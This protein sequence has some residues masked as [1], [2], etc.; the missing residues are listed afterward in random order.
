MGPQASER[1]LDRLREGLTADLLI[2]DL[3]IPREDGALTFQQI[4]QRWPRLAVLVCTG[5][6]QTD[7]GT[8]TLQGE[9]VQLLRKPFRMNELWFAVHQALQ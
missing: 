6:L 1:N 2:L 9:Q 4:R 8:P 3:M 7:P 5:L